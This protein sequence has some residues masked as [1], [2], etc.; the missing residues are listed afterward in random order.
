MG[1]HVLETPEQRR[2]Y[3]SA[4]DRRILRDIQTLLM[5]FKEQSNEQLS[6][7]IGEY[8]HSL[9]VSLA[10]SALSEEERK[11]LDSRLCHCCGDGV[12]VVN[13]LPDCEVSKTG[14]IFYEE[15]TSCDYWGEFFKLKQLTYKWEKGKLKEV[16]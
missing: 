3:F 1:V 6:I 9:G 7:I 11:L 5:R 12:I 10:A 4:W 15:C 13:K 14:R 2:A 8:L 16:I